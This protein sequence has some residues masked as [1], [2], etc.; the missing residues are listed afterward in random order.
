MDVG[1]SVRDPVLDPLL[2]HPVG[3]RHPVPDRSP[4]DDGGSPDITTQDRDQVGRRSEG[5][6]RLLK[7]SEGPESLTG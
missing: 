6:F 2:D 5:S 3:C 4:E 7:M 1:S